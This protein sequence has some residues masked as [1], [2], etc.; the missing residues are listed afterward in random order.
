MSPHRRIT[1]QGVAGL[2]IAEG[3]AELLEEIMTSTPTTQRTSRGLLVPLAAAAAVVAVAGGAWALSTGDDPDVAPRESGFGSDPSAPVETTS[4]PAGTPTD[5]VENTC[6]VGYPEGATPT[7]TDGPELKKCDR[8]ILEEQ[9]PGDVVEE[10]RYQR[11]PRPVLITAHGWEVD[12]VHNMDLDWTGPGDAE[13]HLTWVQTEAEPF[14]YD[15]YERRGERIDVLGLVGRLT[16]FT[17]QGKDYQV[18]VTSPIRNGGPGLIL[19]TS[20]LGPAEFRAVVESL[21]W[22]TLDEYDAVVRPAVG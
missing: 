3:R 14:A 2:P 7:A 17:E 11:P 22:V 4:E 9:Q 6:V 20:S 16:G 15:R 13:V 5:V 8:V 1:D 10:E 19:E 18:L 12:G 21:R